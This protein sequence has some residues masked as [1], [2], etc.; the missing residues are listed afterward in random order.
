MI[1]RVEWLRVWK[2]TV[3]VSSR[4]FHAF[5]EEHDGTDSVQPTKSV[6]FEPFPFVV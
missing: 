5:C 2:E 6:G 4:I 1:A 3:W